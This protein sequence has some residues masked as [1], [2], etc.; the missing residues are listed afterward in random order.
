MPK[1]TN[2]EMQISEFFSL[3]WMGYLY[4]WFVTGPQTSTRMDTSGNIQR[5]HLI[6]YCPHYSLIHSTQTKHNY[7]FM[8]FQPLTA[9]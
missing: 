1:P 8:R 6:F 4:V 2:Q 9:V 5:V 7:Y 3:V